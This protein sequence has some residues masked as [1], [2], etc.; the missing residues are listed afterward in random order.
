M[1]NKITNSLLFAFVAML[2]FACKEDL[3]LVH[4]P[5]SIPVF[6][7]AMVEEP[8]IM[9]GDSI[10]VN[11]KISDKMPLSTLEV[12]VVVNDQLLEKESVRTAGDSYSYSRRFCVPFGPYM[13]D[14]APVEVH[15]SSINVDGFHCDTV[16]MTTIAKRP[17]I[18]TMYMVEQTKSVELKL[19]DPENYI[20]SANNLTFGNSIVF[21]LPTKVTPF[22]RVDWS[23]M[24]FGSVNGALGIVQQGG[25]S[26]KI[27]D[28]SLVG[29][30]S[31]K[32]DLFNFTVTATGEKLEP[33][34]AINIATFTDKS[35]ASTDYLNV[36]TSATWKMYQLYLGQNV[37]ITF[38]GI[39]N[40]ANGLTP[41]FFEVTGTNT[42]KFLGNTGVYTLYYLPSADYLWV[43]QPNATFPDVL[44][45]DGVGFG[46]PATPYAK[47]SSWNWNS[48]L[49]YAFC[50]T[51]SPGVYQVTMY[52]NHEI[53]SDP[54][55]GWRYNFSAKFFYQ[56]GWGSGGTGEIDARQYTISTNL[57][58][59]PADHDQGNFYGTDAFATAPGV[60]LLTLDTNAKTASFVKIK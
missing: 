36:T 20:Y 37:E 18:P 21:L 43:E 45:F 52:A 19:T 8:L 16:I 27:S 10:T 35:I 15:L 33:A 7:Q 54:A 39:G 2:F 48:P 51:V 50:R 1:K 5:K 12:M 41:D 23:G 31:V 28:P 13:P 47:T 6:Q 32:L 34:T 58:I 56:R 60:Y 53:N 25:D 30:N 42:A 57:L 46:R 3:S 17:S 11:A 29:I 44:W 38:T 4:Y 14:N 22:M 26:I 9:Y 49:E 55:T 59:A 40:L 24:V